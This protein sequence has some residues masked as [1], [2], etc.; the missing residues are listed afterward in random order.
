MDTVAER[1]ARCVLE[2]GSGTTLSACGAPELARHAGLVGR[3]IPLALSSGA[4]GR[5]MLEAEAV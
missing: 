4:M 3:R 2:V 1:L 5:P